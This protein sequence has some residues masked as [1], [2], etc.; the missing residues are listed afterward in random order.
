MRQFIKRDISI[1][2]YLSLPICIFWWSWFA[3]WVALPCTIGLAYVILQSKTQNK[4]LGI[5]GTTLT[6]WFNINILTSIMPPIPSKSTNNHFFFFTLAFFL[7]YFS[8]IGGFRPQHF[9]YYK[10]NLILNNLVLFDWPVRYSDG[11]YLCYNHFYYLLPAL[12]AKAIGCTDAVGFYQFGWAWLGLSLLFRLLY[13]IGQWRFILFFLFFGSLQIVFYGI[14]FVK[15]SMGLLDFIKDLFVTDHT[16]EILLFPGGLRYPNHVKMLASAPQYA[17]A[18]WLMTGLVLEFLAKS[19]YENR[20]A[21]ATQLLVVLCLSLY[22][23]PLLFVGLLPFVLFSIMSN[24]R[25]LLS[26]SWILVVCII[27]ALIFYG[28]HQPIRDLKG[29]LWEFI[30]SPHQYL[31]L[32]VFLCLTSVF[33]AIVF[34]F[35]KKQEAVSTKDFRFVFIALAILFLLPF[36]HFGYYNDLMLRASQPAILILCW[37]V[38]RAMIIDFEG[39]FWAK[40]LRNSLLCIV[41]LLPMVNYVELLLGKPYREVTNR[42]VQDFTPHTIHY[43]NHYHKANF[44]AAAQYLGD[45]NSVYLRYFSK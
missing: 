2:L 19:L 31:L 26:K 38:Y 12:L 41:A 16:I 30:H 24:I 34:W 21:R 45:S 40:F 20:A 36:Y 1:I 44:N 4:K 13:D 35:M 23:S 3:W 11:S 5:G 7:T 42:S 15:S 28:G 43:L 17:I 14:A 37:G 39:G 32:T 8:G 18:G 22:W 29:F 10:H 6:K 27:P 9:D 33:W 25:K